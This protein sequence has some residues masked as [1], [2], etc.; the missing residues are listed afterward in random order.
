MNRVLRTLPA[1]ILVALAIPCVLTLM[2]RS[3]ADLL[4][5]AL[6]PRLLSAFGPPPSKPILSIATWRSGAFQ[7]NV[8]DSFA[9]AFVPRGPMIQAINQLYYS[10]LGKSDMYGKHIIIGHDEELYES[11]AIDAACTPRSLAAP[12]RFAGLAGKLGAL[13][14]R[15]AQRDKLLVFVISPTKPEVMP[16]FL[17]AGLCAN[18][19]GPG[20]DRQL[21]GRLLTQAGVPVFDTAETILAMMQ[22]DPLPPFPRGG[23]HWSR[24]AARR[25]SASLMQRIEQA[26]GKDYG[27]FGLT[28]PRWDAP[29]IGS[30]LDLAELLNL[31]HPPFDYPTGAAD[32][33]CRTT[34]L[35]QG[36]GLL[37]VGD[38]FSEQLSEPMMTC[39]LFGRA[40]YLF[41]YDGFDLDLKTQ[42]R[43]EVDRTPAGWSVLLD[44]TQVILVEVNDA[45]IPDGLLFLERFATDALAAGN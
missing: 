8:T 25:I 28:P 20:P 12:E 21:L 33:R 38:S 41:Y 32:L 18:T 15:L 31:W 19:I 6:K 40:D 22:Q 34:P 30:D 11:Y 1:L 7:R 27:G 42:R 9:L 36:S 3:G 45:F 26:S 23:T 39:D 37:V 16:E 29:P 43:R 13:H 44:R 35:G 2:D 17:P 4:P 24:L 10:L 14:D 5:A